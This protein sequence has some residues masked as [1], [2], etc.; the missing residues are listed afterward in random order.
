M[1]ILYIGHL[2]GTCRHRMDALARLNHEVIPFD[3]TPYSSFGG[4]ARR[5]LRWRTLVG[6]RVWRLNTTIRAI[7]P[8]HTYDLVW[9]DKAQ[10]LWP[11]T[12]RFLRRA[13]ASI[14]HYS[15]DLPSTIRGEPGWQ[16]FRRAVPDYDAVIAPSEGH[17]TVYRALGARNLLYLPFGF[18]PAC[19]FPPPIDWDDHKRPYDVTFIGSNYENRGAFLLS[20]VRDFG[21]KVHIFGDGWEKSLPAADRTALN[22]EP[23]RHGD[24]YRETLWQ[25][26]IS[27]GF[28]TH[29]MAHESARRWSEITACQSFLLAERTP[30]AEKWFEPDQEACFFSSVRE[31]AEHIQTALT[32]TPRR[33]AIAR[34][35][36]E[37]IAL[38]NDND[39]L[40]ADVIGRILAL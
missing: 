15:S 2:S 37:R 22:V 19:H 7:A 38:G 29:T 31:C 11:S 33:E 28:V 40:M 20:L 13:G 23:G 34:R 12:V 32:D 10:M 18:E 27:L 24:A 17:R 14:V 39:S 6:T 35:G 25:S 21:I 26:K 16:L 9:C 30:S 4:R 5:W 3:L 36:R 8:G 1:K